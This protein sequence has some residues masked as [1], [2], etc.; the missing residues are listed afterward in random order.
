MASRGR[1]TTLTPCMPVPVR[2]ADG[3]LDGD[4][5]GGGELLAGEAGEILRG[6]GV[7]AVEGGDVVVAQD[8]GVGNA[9]AAG[10]AAD[11][12]ERL[13]D[14]PALQCRRRCCFGGRRG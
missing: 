5:V 13:H 1:A 8:G 12:A 14:G 7:D 3:A 11:A 6:D 9:L 4:G 2:K 10:W